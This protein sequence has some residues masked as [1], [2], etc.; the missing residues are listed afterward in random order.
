MQGMGKPGSNIWG[1]TQGAPCDESFFFP[2][3]A[4][5]GISGDLDNTASSYQFANRMFANTMRV[6]RSPINLP[7][8]QHIPRLRIPEAIMDQHIP[9]WRGKGFCGASI[10]EQFHKYEFPAP[11]Y[12]HIQMLYRYGGSFIGTMTET[13]RY[14]KMYQT[15]KLPIAVAQAIWFEGETKFADIILPACT[16]FERWDISEFANCSGYIP[17]SFTQCNHRVISL[18][19]KCIELLWTGRTPRPRGRIHGWREDRTRLGEADLPCDR[20][21]HEDHL[22]RVLQEGLLRGA[23]ESEGQGQSDGGIALVR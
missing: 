3:Y 10:E 12:A 14:V 11:G 7:S 13:N 1:T 4:E 18:Q 2:G 17:H 23:A 22:G 9:E 15:D 8:G 21:T 5:G 16:N 20:P 19:M 6:P